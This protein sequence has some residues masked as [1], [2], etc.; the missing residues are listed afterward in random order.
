VAFP[1]AERRSL[2]TTPYKEKKVSAGMFSFKLF[3]FLK[4]SGLKKI[5]GKWENTQLQSFL[6]FLQLHYLFR[7]KEDR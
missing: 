6:V 3:L 4:F 2:P 7:N 1:I 5:Q